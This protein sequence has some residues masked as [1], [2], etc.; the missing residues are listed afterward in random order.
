MNGREHR[1]TLSHIAR[2]AC[3]RGMHRILSRH[4]GPDGRLIKPYGWGGAFAFQCLDFVFTLLHLPVIHRMAGLGKGRSLHHLQTDDW[5]RSDTVFI[6]GTGASINALTREE[7]AHIAGNDSIGFNFWPV[8][9]FVPSMLFFELSHNDQRDRVHAALMAYRNDAYAC[10]PIA[11]NIKDS[12]TALDA[13]PE[14]MR[15]RLY[16]YSAFN[17]ARSRGLLRCSLRAFAYA[18][19]MGIDVRR[20]LINHS[21]SLSTMILFAIL[22]GYK[23]IVLLGVDLNN[24]AYFWEGKA[25]YAGVPTPPNTQNAQVHSSLDP[26]NPHSLTIVQF[27]EILKATRFPNRDYTLYIGN[28]DSALAAELD[29]YE[30]P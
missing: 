2:G 25:A 4:T 3:R 7:W 29:V 20:M 24:T 18:A 16:L 6:L 14:T 22:S 11:V 17:G 26:R 19:R 10:T 9:P 28:P 1:R 21:G 23:D 30:F 13:Y 8:H 5:K 27:L 12:G 15:N